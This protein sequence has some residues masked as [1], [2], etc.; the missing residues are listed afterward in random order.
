MFKSANSVKSPLANRPDVKT[1]NFKTRFNTIRVLFEVIFKKYDIIFYPEYGIMTDLLLL[2]KSIHKSNFIFHLRHSIDSKHQNKTL[3]KLIE[4][5]VNI[6]SN[7][8]FVAET[9]NTFFD[10]K[11]KTIFNGIDRNLFYPPR[12]RHESDQLKV[13]YIGSFQ[14]RK[15]P[16]V[17]LDIAKK[18]P[19]V[20]FSMIGD[21]PMYN[22]IKH[23]IIVNKISNVS[24][25]KSVKYDEVGSYMRDSDIF[26]F[27]SIHEGH[28]Q[29]LGQACGCGLPVLAMDLIKPNYIIHNKNGFL[30]KNDEE[31][32]H[33]FNKLIN[34]KL[35]RTNFSEFSKRHCLNFDWKKI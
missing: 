2:T 27:P 31:L 8:Y 17:V 33:Y 11:I 23:L 35:I 6:I 21:G 18:Y 13:L 20:S 1:F 14:K 34:D 4:N 10:Y 26:L 15:R 30:A 24:L 19:K 25:V 29:V 22:Q 3:I 28:P 12:K 9:F 7:S 32:N 5:K 16:N